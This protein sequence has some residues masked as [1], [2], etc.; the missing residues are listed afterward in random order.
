MSSNKMLKMIQ[1]LDALVKDLKGPYSS[2]IEAI[3]GDPQIGLK[4]IERI[5]EIMTYL[6]SFAGG[7]S[8]IG[9]R[10]SANE[11]NITGISEEVNS[12]KSTDLLYLRQEVQQAIGSYSSLKEAVK[13]SKSIDVIVNEGSLSLD[14]TSVNAVKSF[15]VFVPKGSSVTINTDIDPEESFVSL[16]IKELKSGVVKDVDVRKETSFSMFS[17]AYAD[18]TDG[19]GIKKGEL[20]KLLD[21]NLIKYS[22]DSKEHQLLETEHFNVVAMFPRKDSRSDIRNLFRKSTD[23]YSDY[24]YLNHRT[25]SF[26][27]VIHLK[28]PI[29]LEKIRLYPNNTDHQPK[30]KMMAYDEGNLLI[31]EMSS[32]TDPAIAND[33]TYYT[34]VEINDVV[35]YITLELITSSEGSSVIGFNK[36]EMYQPDMPL[37]SDIAILNGVRM[38]PIDVMNGITLATTNQF[39][40]TRNAEMKYALMIDN[41]FNVFIPKEKTVSA[42]DFVDQYGY[43]PKKTVIADFAP[44]NHFS[45][46]HYSYYKP[47]LTS[48]PDLGGWSI[49]RSSSMLQTP[50][51]NDGYGARA[52][53]S[54]E[55]LRFKT[56]NGILSNSVD[57][58]YT[59][60]DRM[61]IDGIPIKIEKV[62]MNDEVMRIFVDIE[63]ESRRNVFRL[64]SLIDFG[65]A[66]FNSYNQLSLKT[67]DPVGY[68]KGLE[69]RA[70]YSRYNTIYSHLFFYFLPSNITESNFT[71]DNSGGKNKMETDLVEL[72]FTIYIGSN[73]NAA[74]N[75]NYMEASGSSN[76]TY[77]KYKTRILQDIQASYGT[78]FADQ[79]I[80]D[81]AKELLKQKHDLFYYEINSDLY[82]DGFDISNV[83]ASEEVKFAFLS[84][85]KY[86]AYR[87]SNGTWESSSE[88]SF[89]RLNGMSPL[90]IVSFTKESLKSKNFGNLK[91]VVHVPE[92]MSFTS[93][94]INTIYDK[95][96][97]CSIDDLLLHG[98]DS[99]NVSSSLLYNSVK[100][101]NES[102]IQLITVSKFKDEPA[103]ILKTAKYTM[104]GIYAIRPLNTTEQNS[105]SA[106]YYRDS[107]KFN[108][109]SAS[110]VN[111]LVKMLTPQNV[112]V[113]DNAS[114]VEIT[115]V[116]NK[117]N[118]LAN[119]SESIDHFVFAASSVFRGYVDESIAKALT[120]KDD[121]SKT[122]I[123]IMNLIG[124]GSVSSD[125]FVRFMGDKVDSFISTGEKYALKD[126]DSFASNIYMKLSSTLDTSIKTPVIPI[127]SGTISFKMN[128]K[129]DIAPKTINLIL[130]ETI[131]VT[132][133]IYIDGEVFVD[134]TI[135][136]LEFQT[137]MKVTKVQL[138][139]IFD[140]STVDDSINVIPK[141][142]SNTTPSGTAY[143]STQYDNSS[144]PA[145]IAFD[146]VLE[147]HGWLCQN[148][149]SY[150]Y[151]G[152]KWPLGQKKK[153]SKI[154][155]TSGTYE[156]QHPNNIRIV[157]I[158]NGVEITLV[159]NFIPN[160]PTTVNG[161]IT[162]TF[163]PTF[164][165]EIRLYVERPGAPYT[166][167][168]NIEVFESAA[169][170]FDYINYMATIKGDV[171]TDEVV[172]MQQYAIQISSDGMTE[173]KIMPN[174]PAEYKILI[175]GVE[176]V[177]HVDYDLEQRADGCYMVWKS[178]DFILET[179]DEVV[180]VTS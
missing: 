153:A 142:T 99:P 59:G 35:S 52:W 41:E 115:E 82:S 121:I 5:D 161:V 27:I 169:V 147:Q 139:L 146:R 145:W 60:I 62:M 143:A 43:K 64:K 21:Y 81:D 77:P 179:E 86:H 51:M 155:I 93:L 113:V 109:A 72:P 83:I 175:N 102:D 112:K 162:K 163:Q 173:I 65:Y 31:K 70:N 178:N 152:Y 38:T 2:L 119:T 78:Y 134:V 48:F 32:Y 98:A 159:D 131:T 6:S 141:M 20:G 76:S 130:N 156:P 91:L 44:T 157:G 180:L 136:E 125:S 85:G 29:Y 79:V 34:D 56:S 46:V 164:I 110:D 137:S 114:S 120:T 166:G 10:L 84:N 122:L 63:D 138:E 36:L 22:V 54:A 103:P 53:F 12:I 92:G 177:K 97:R 19:Y 58:A 174:M 18:F 17:K 8:N 4:N 40:K 45:K 101:K 165:D 66:S 42:G 158:I 118:E 144:Y 127:A 167:L 106:E 170:C 154:R 132:K 111:L 57:F 107:V 50:S 25:G 176:Q 14:F 149:L 9:E 33:V 15:P 69:F 148:G 30:Y 23:L 73:L 49:S 171:L 61:T 3:K 140:K 55:N 80:T 71:L 16:N 87:A 75:S 67:P 126:Y 47:S 13:N 1:E 74:I 28:R 108:N 123:P 116:M 128:A 11:A 95:I 172:R 160:W 168:S 37:D 94:K 88:L 100:D 24:I 89:V 117:A 105:I 133:G 7:Y 39:Y 135:E 104:N 26:P 129:C 124:F 150:G 90:D 68:A 96:V 151:V